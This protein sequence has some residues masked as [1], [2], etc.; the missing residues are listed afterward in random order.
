MFLKRPIIQQD[1]SLGSYVCRV[2]EANYYESIITLGKLF[3]FNH[4]N[5]TS[6]SFKKE[7]LEDLSIYLKIE[8]EELEMYTCDFVR[9]RL[10]IKTENYIKSYIR[11]CPICISR[12]GYHKWI[13]QINY[14]SVCLEHHIYLV[15]RCLQCNKR[16]HLHELLNQGCNNCKG[17]GT[18]ITRIKPCHEELYTQEIIYQC[19]VDE[20]AVKK[21]N[22]L[23]MNT[24]NNFV[25]LGKV[26]LDEQ[27]SF[28]DANQTIRIKSTSTKPDDEI[29]MW[30]YFLTDTFYLFE[31]KKAL[32]IALGNIDKYTLKKRSRKWNDVLRIC[33]TINTPHLRE[34]VEEYLI[35]RI[36]NGNA[37]K[38]T[39]LL[40]QRLE[41]E[42][43]NIFL[44]S[45]EIRERWGLSQDE[46][47]C[48]VEN[49][50]II[51]CP[52]NAK[53][54]ALAYVIDNIKEFE[55]MLR[56]KK[57]L[58]SI[59]G[60]AKFLG[61]SVDTVRRLMHNGVISE[62]RH[63]SSRM[64]FIDK[65][66]LEKFVYDIS[67]RQ[68]K[69]L[70]ISSKPLSQLLMKSAKLGINTEQFYDELQNSGIKFYYLST[71][72]KLA[73]LW[74]DAEGERWIRKLWFEQ[75]E[76][77]NL[78]EA[79]K[80]IGVTTG[81]LK[82]MVQKELLVLNKKN[83]GCYLFSRGEVNQF[84]DNYCSVPIC[85]KEL[86]ISAA[87]IRSWVYDRTIKNYFEDINKNRF[88]INKKE[89]VSVMKKNVI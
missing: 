38:N 81:V 61:V 85:S 63:P 56:E 12:L 37:E 78:E 1:E 21:T 17:F 8:S 22:V 67:K 64:I 60:A 44:K 5:V 84:M 52:L 40:Y 34:A 36:L 23:D 27:T 80:T 19:I 20:L 35:E 3:K 55:E 83:S 46:F 24:L 79:A 69:V 45:I 54:R 86:G 73:D 9:R 2:S 77:L 32:Q 53:K 11:F 50:V 30:S 59:Q 76:Y 49:Q 39:I 16:L 88:L 29:L 43:S 13:W 14:V 68:V 41:I 70:P 87:I 48:L 65:R 28:L 57:H 47:R 66:L 58:I 31:N 72:P 82:R 7:V 71:Q 15:D 75:K 51:G 6:G 26:L 33:K 18:V 10:G 74:I 25:Q 42:H 62:S 4:F 89:V